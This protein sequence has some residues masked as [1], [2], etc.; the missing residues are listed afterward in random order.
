M[1]ILLIKFTKINLLK[2]MVKGKVTIYMITKSKL[3]I[4][5]SLISISSLLLF[6]HN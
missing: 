1:Q 2:L 3:D 4:L 5:F 6:H